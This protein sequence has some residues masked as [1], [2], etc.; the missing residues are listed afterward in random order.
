M[1]KI[2]KIIIIIFVF[3]NTH[4]V[5]SDTISG[6]D[7]FLKVQIHC[8]ENKFNKK[9]KAW[10]SSFYA[11]ATKHTL[12]GSRYWTSSN[13]ANGIGFH[14]FNGKKNDKQFFIHGKG[15]YTKSNEKWKLYFSSEGNLSII[16]HLKKQVHG[17]QGEGES[18]VKCRLSLVEAFDL[19]KAADINNIERRARLAKNALENTHKK[20]RSLRRELDKIK[21]L[22]DKEK[23]NNSEY[24]DNINN[25][26]NL[27][28][29]ENKSNISLL[30][31]IDELEE[32]KKLNKI[33]NSEK[34]QK[35]SKLND[36][37][38]DLN[39]AKEQYSF[40]SLENEKLTKKIKLVEDE[41]NLLTT[42]INELNLNKEQLT[43]K[44]KIKDSVIKNY[45]N[46]INQLNMDIS[47]QAEKQEKFVEAAK[48]QKEAEEKALA[49]K[50]AEEEKKA[51]IQAEI[52]KQEKIEQE[53]FNSLFELMS[54]NRIKKLTNYI[55]N[56]QFNKE[57]N[58]SFSLET[59]IFDENNCTIGIGN[60][61]NRFLKIFWK[62]VDYK[63][64]KIEKNNSFI[65][66][67]I[68]SKNKK[69]V[70]ELNFMSGKLSN[71]L[72]EAFESQNLNYTGP[73]PTL[74]ASLIVPLSKSI[75]YENYLLKGSLNTLIN[76]LC[77]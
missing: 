75:N 9:Q 34:D 47:K 60:Q 1:E 76:E 64:L 71:K 36:I 49:K 20:L 31:K 8:E 66:L 19:S 58:N 56:G 18:K 69:N 7:K 2:Y 65:Y 29:N 37:L 68:S 54:G 26:K 74:T 13:K 40:A 3:L 22:L 41:N 15:F 16:E 24:I 38:E 53:K 30:K 73:N 25:L 46:K 32:Y 43:N 51:E 11:I 70:A 12:L 33:Q 62:N 63:S 6:E 44:L 28:D 5:Y 72:K 21:K 27:I 4:Y 48:A 39:S 35:I 77:D 61:K 14:V 45:Q 59:N 10:T 52:A 50:K 55:F 67:N 17:T 42:E 57:F 23:E